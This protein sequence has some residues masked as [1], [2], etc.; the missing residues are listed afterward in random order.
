M[1]ILLNFFKNSHRKDYLLIKGFLS[2]KN[3]HKKVS[4]KKSLLKKADYFYE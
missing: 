3:N 1:R 2:I 4:S